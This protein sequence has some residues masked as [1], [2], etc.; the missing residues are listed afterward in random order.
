MSSQSVHI[1]KT[2][3][4]ISEYVTPAREAAGGRTVLAP[5]D[6]S[7]HSAVALNFAVTIAESM[8]AAL[9]VLHIIHDPADMP[10]YYSS[11]IKS[12]HLERI[13]DIAKQAFEEFM[14][15]VIESHPDSAALRA[16]ESIMVVGLPVTRILEVAA[17][18]DPIM[19]VM[20]SNGRTGLDN[21]II[22]SKAAQ[23]VQLSQYPV[24]IVKNP[25]KPIDD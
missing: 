25:E 4:D 6:F 11:L 17:E 8:Q 20:G 14:S 22:G 24:T 10:G 21:L 13:D 7:D 2:L 9:V 3:A 16:A 15:R 18:L 1:A 19:I 23:I 5:V 12:T